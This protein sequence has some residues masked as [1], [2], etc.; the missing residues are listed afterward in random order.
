MSTELI[1]FDLDDTL[2][3]E[4]DYNL[5]GLKAVSKFIDESIGGSPSYLFL[6]HEYLYGDRSRIFDNV[7]LNRGVHSREMVV[8]LVDIY[9]EHCPDI[10]PCSDVEI[11][12]RKL[13]ERY[14]LAI[15]SDG[16]LVSQTRKFAALK[17]AE[18][19]DEVCFTD[20]FG[21]EFWKPHKRAFV[22][23]ADKLGVRH[24]ACMYI[25][26]NIGKDFIAPNELGWQTVQI[27]RA[28][29]I[30]QKQQASVE[31]EPKYK[32]CSLYELKVILDG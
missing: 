26:D 5:S 12:L 30:H 2:Y 18:Y 14:K 13:R 28:N 17:L 27:L 6:E 9:R 21:K 20:S 8:R 22:F 31:E 7:L 19:F 4:R 25:G 1:V 29:R 15:V 24:E 23:V 16:Y 10:K 11:V 32:I 3:F